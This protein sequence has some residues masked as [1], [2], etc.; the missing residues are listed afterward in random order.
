[1]ANKSELVKL[2]IGEA[3]KAEAVDVAAEQ[4]ESLSA[5]IRQS[6]REYIDRYREKEF[7][8]QQ[9][10]LDFEGLRVAEDPEI[11][12]GPDALDD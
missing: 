3:L 1:M 7:R 2:R 4:D 10:E 11:I 8:Y 5:I 12:D 6:L 9:K